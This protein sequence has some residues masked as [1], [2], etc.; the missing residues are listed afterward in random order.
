MDG[1]VILLVFLGSAIV[2]F[3]V[4]LIKESISKAIDNKFH[5][6]DMQNEL[7]EL[8]PYKK[9]HE[10]RE[11]SLKQIFSSNLEA[12]PYLAGIMADY[13]T[14]DIHLI[15]EGFSYGYPKRDINR[16][17]KIKGI[18]DE[19]KERIAESRLAY[20]QLEYLKQLFPDI[21]EY[22]SV[23]FSELPQT[24]THAFTDEDP[25]RS[26]VSKIE[27]DT[28]SESQRNQLALDRYIQSHKKSNW[29]IGRDYELYVGYVYSKNGYNVNFFGSYQKLEDMGRD[30][31]IKRN[32]K[33]AIVQCKYWSNT[34]LIHEKHVAQLYGTTIS[35]CIE[36][37]LPV[38]SVTAIL[39][40]N[41]SLSET[42]KTMA[43]YL[44]V[45][46]KEHYEMGEFPRIKCN[47]G[48]NEFGLE[49]KIYHLPM[50]AQYDVVKLDK[51]GEFLAFTVTEA[52]AA[53]FRRAYKW[54]G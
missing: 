16:S 50:D 33:T 27:W 28:L 11:K 25:T 35:Y 38:G 39:I 18:R 19:A 15:A 30:L 2:F 3:L 53:G 20:Y 21:E 36:N 17:I 40:T 54:H 37:K 22:L 32:G 12:L 1:L 51:K 6:T 43:E 31:I 34:K 5:I 48:K 45:K 44:K 46:Y 26:Y 14:Y 24:T 49:A 23:K 47:I 41:T 42:A 29:Q 9:Y 4:T 52:E 8:R 10:E 13:M 7:T